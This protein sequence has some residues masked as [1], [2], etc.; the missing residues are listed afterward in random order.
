LHKF[1]C[2]LSEPFW[3]DADIPKMKLVDQPNFRFMGT[4]MPFSWEAL[5]A[6]WVQSGDRIQAVV[7][8]NVAW[9]QLELDR[10]KW[11]MP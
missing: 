11:P 5:T 8:R 2:I 6:Q 10:F 9:V 3:E 4:C 1:A 7:I